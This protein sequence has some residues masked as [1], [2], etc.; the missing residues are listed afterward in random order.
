MG[1]RDGVKEEERMITTEEAIEKII[2]Q[3][4]HIIETAESEN[5]TAPEEKTSKEVEILFCNADT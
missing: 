1:E 3:V 4:D 5:G 2:G